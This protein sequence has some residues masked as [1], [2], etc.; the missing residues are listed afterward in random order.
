MAR[1]HIKIIILVCFVF[2]AYEYQTIVIFAKENWEYALWVKNTIR[3]KKYT[4]DSEESTVFKEFHDSVTY[5]EDDCNGLC[6]YEKRVPNEIF[7]KNYAKH[8]F[9]Y[10]DTERIYPMKEQLA[11]MPKTFGY[12]KEEGDDIFP[13]VGYPRCSSK[14]ADPY[15]ILH[16]DVE[17]NKLS[18]NCTEKS[19]GRYLLGSPSDRKLVMRREIE[20]LWELKEYKNEANLK[21]H[22]DFAFGTCD[23]K[24]EKLDRAVYNFRKNETAAEIALQNMKRWQSI[25]GVSSKPLIVFL[26]V[27]DSY[28]RKHFFRKMPKSVE[29]LNNLNAGSQYE[30]FD[31]LIHN[32]YGGNSVA[33]QVPILARKLYYRKSYCR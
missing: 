19:N 28:S 27:I 20:H 16:L 26:F 25:T 8:K 14:V 6:S 23:P 30:V 4:R 32:V 11:C 9:S 10:N 7:K 5:K 18:M 33:N 15:P 21:S 13:Y 22:H 31:F 1:L 12:S 24:A 3:A 17:R 29:Y 2:L